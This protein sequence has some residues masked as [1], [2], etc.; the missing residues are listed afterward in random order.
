MI[1]V[2]QGAIL[3]T[4]GVLQQ[5]DRPPAERR[6][7]LQLVVDVPVETKTDLN[8]VAT[9]TK[10]S[11]ATELTY[12]VAVALYL[13]GQAKYIRVRWKRSIARAGGKPRR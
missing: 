9:T 6:R 13:L 7:L 8:K 4:P 2:V 11:Q 3:D 5:P 12:R 10:V 1:S